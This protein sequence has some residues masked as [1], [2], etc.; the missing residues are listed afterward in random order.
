MT[1]DEAMQLAA[2]AAD[3]AIEDTMIAPIAAMLAQFEADG[4]TL[5]QFQTALEDMTGTLDP[6]ALREVLDRA[7][8]YAMLRGAATKVA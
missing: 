5:A 3:Q 7:L 4:K 8:S 6:E 1:E 2:D